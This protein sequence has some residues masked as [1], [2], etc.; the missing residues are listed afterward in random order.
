MT[1]QTND[2][3]LEV[4]SEDGWPVGDEIFIGAAAPT[5]Q[6]GG[7]PVKGSCHRVLQAGNTGTAGASVTMKSVKTQEAPSMVWII[8]DQ[9]VN[10][11][12]VFCGLGDN[13]N[14]AANASFAIPAL[15]AAVFCRI[16]AQIKR[17]GG[18]SGGG[19]IDWRASTLA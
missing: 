7:Q 10:G 18:V 4:L 17:K 2:A 1:Q 15:T 9:P 6:A 12:V 16:P 8:N 3:L 13:M 14:G 5:A 19:T 11:I